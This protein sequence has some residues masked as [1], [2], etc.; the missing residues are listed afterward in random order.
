MWFP[1]RTECMSQKTQ[2]QYVLLTVLEKAPK[3][4]KSTIYL[5]PTCQMFSELTI[6]L[7]KL[8]LL[9]V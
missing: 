5:Y 7:R 3:A 2:D 6:H 9:L 4:T 8:Y 1:N